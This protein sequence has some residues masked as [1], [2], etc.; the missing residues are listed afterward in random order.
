MTELEQMA[1]RPVDER[2]ILLLRVIDSI[3]L[4]GLECSRDSKLMGVIQQVREYE[5]RGWPVSVEM[6]NGRSIASDLLV[7]LLAHEE[8]FL[9]LLG[10]TETGLAATIEALRARIGAEVPC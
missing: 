10:S 8:G 3:D 1:G 4:V 9:R 7:S 6:Q 5:D 2:Q